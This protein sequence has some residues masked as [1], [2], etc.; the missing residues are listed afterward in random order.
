MKPLAN[1]DTARNLSRCMVEGNS[2]WAHFFLYQ[3][4]LSIRRTL[5]NCA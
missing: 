3:G 2:Y 5:K 1:Q 4:I